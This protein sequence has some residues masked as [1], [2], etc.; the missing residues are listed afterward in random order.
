MSDECAVRT[1]LVPLDLTPAGEVKIP[2]AEEYARALEADVLLLHVLR[3]GSLDPTTVS[4]TEAMA[5]T[6]LDTFE[7][8]LRNA[9][10]HTESVIRSGAPA[11][12]IVQEALIRDVKLIVLGT[13]TRPLL[14]TAVLGSVA[15]QV[16]RAAPCPVLLV[17]PH[18]D[19]L[20]RPP[21][22][23][24][25]EDAELAGVLVR[26]DLG[27]RTVEV[28]RI[29]GSVD[30]CHELGSDFRP[31]VR[32]RRRQDEERFQRVRRALQAEVQMPLIE[33]YKLGFGYYVLDGHHR[34]AVAI[35][36]GQIEIEAH[37]LEYVS[38]T[39]QQA[40]ERYRSGR[41]PR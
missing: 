34:V 33:L 27:I 23:C 16:A 3:R 39:D 13:N 29:V 2:V 36:H 12:T 24:F 37:V 7:A 25:Q 26:R 20:E 11:P 9:G 5:R 4:P 38:V 32:R 1:I 30:R 14:S 28:A 6:Y 41:E 18:G 15:D 17:R 40:P 35:E 21:L 10:I 19:T 8:R 31:P 22:R